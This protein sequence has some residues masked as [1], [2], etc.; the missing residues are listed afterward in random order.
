MPWHEEPLHLVE[1]DCSTLLCCICDSLCYHA[2]QDLEAH[3]PRS[4]GGLVG[5]IDREA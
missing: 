1:L 5:A 4:F 2:L 3:G